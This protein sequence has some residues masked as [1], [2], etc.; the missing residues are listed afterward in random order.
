MLFGMTQIKW[1]EHLRCPRCE[2]TG[3]VK[4][5]EI[6]PFKNVVQRISDGFKV[7][8]DEYGHDFHCETCAVAV[9]Q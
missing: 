7:I 2:K 5:H 8:T 6:S 9:A 3:K 1:T 4:L